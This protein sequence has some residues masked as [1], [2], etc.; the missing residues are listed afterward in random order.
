MNAQLEK[1]IKA[2]GLTPEQAELVRKKYGKI[3]AVSYFD[4]PEFKPNFDWSMFNPVPDFDALYE[5]MAGGFD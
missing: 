3:P 4:Y 5:R 2:A 1:D